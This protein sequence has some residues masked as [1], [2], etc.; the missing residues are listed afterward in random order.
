MLHFLVLLILGG[1]CLRLLVGRLAQRLSLRHV[2]VLGGKLLLSI[3]CTR[4]FHVMS[5]L[6]C[7]RLLLLLLLLRFRVFS[8]LFIVVPL[9]PTGLNSTGGIGASIRLSLEFLIS[10][11]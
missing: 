9:L 4:L 3:H 6:V 11:R 5:L 8:H 1:C 10:A 7:V 2:L